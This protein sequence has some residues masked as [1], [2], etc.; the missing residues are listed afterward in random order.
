MTAAGPKILAI[1]DSPESLENLE[2]A[3]AHI[4][5]GAAFLA[6]QNAR[7][8]LE[9][10]LAHDPDLILLDVVMPEMDG[11]EACVSIKGDMRLR[12]IPVL[13]ITAI[14]PDK[15]LCERAFGTGAEAFITK[16]LK[17]WE[18]AVQIRAMIKLKASII[19]QQRERARLQEMVSRRTRELTQELAL[20]EKALEKMAES[21]LLFKTVF[22]RAPM[23][24]GLVD[25]GTGRYL[26]ANPALTALTGRSAEELSALTWRHITHPEDIGSVEEGLAAL[27]LDNSDIFRTEKRCLR[28]D[29][30]AVPV[31]LIITSLPAY[32]NSS[33]RF[34][35]I[36]EDISSVKDAEQEKLLLEE[37]LRQSQKMET[38]GKLAGGI[39]HDFN[40]IIAAILAY[41]DFLLKGLAGGRPRREDAE[42][43]KKAGLRAAALTRQLLAFSRKQVMNPE[44]LDANQVLH[45]MAIMLGRL[46]GEDIKLSIVTQRVPVYVKADPCHLEQVLLNLC[47]NARDAMPRG[48]RLV[49]EASIVRMGEVYVQRHGTIT[50]GDYVL[51]SVSYTGC[52]MSAEVQSHIFEPFFTTKPRD[53]GTGL[54]LS[55]VHGIVKQSGGHIVVYSEEGHGTVFKL[56]FPP[57]APAATAVEGPKAEPKACAAGGAVLVVDDD[58]QMRAVIR[59][60]LAADGFE[61]LEAGSA[62]EALA[63]CGRRG[64][65]LSLLLTDMVLPELNGFELARRLRSRHPDL[66]V[67]FMSGYTEHAALE[68]EILDPARNFIQKPFTLDTLTR[69]VREAL[70][71]AGTDAK[72]R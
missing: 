17:L 1:D 44:V 24:I 21:E 40:N 10:A 45:G 47:V 30:S 13:L 68:D 38:A 18:L 23:G 56:Y 55:T 4:F 42:E 34:L 72:R 71:S 67:L 46:L 28:R 27:S 19:T 64:S 35:T 29:G 15:A 11:F 69:K 51:L 5:P 6:A 50:P 59:R 8:G 36:A 49:L 22:A 33:T 60:L 70:P 53:K 43:I 52:G 20:R 25:S 62:E 14:E 65:P 57:A 37:Q 31:K 3:I 41:S 58:V 66:P 63:V 54:G 7:K 32:D 9:L 39:A 48:G 16:P 2:A 61:V 12:D 26:R